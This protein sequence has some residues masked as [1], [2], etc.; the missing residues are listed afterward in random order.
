MIKIHT[1][2]II[3]I[4]DFIFFFVCDGP[5]DA[6]MGIW[7]LRILFGKAWIAENVMVMD[8]A[9]PPHLPL[10]R[11]PRLFGICVWPAIGVRSSGGSVCSHPFGSIFRDE[12]QRIFILLIL[13]VRPNIL[14]F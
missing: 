1:G 4:L 6:E 8:W 14:T 10:K 9:V 11:P 13:S 3:E 2:K 12:L 5:T 7:V